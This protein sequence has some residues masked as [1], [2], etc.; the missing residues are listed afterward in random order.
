MG[1]DFEE[2]K[3]LLNN[4]AEFIK[5][6]ESLGHFNI[7]LT[8]AS[9]QTFDY[10]QLHKHVENITVNTGGNNFP[11]CSRYSGGCTAYNCETHYI[12][13]NISAYDFSTCNF[14]LDGNFQ[15]LRAFHFDVNGEHE[16]K[17]LDVDDLLRCICLFNF[18]AANYAKKTKC[19]LSLDIKLMDNKERILVTK[20][21]PH[22]SLDGNYESHSDEI[23]LKLK[24]SQDDMYDKI[25][26]NITHCLKN[27]FPLFQFMENKEGEIKKISED[28]ITDYMRAFKE[29]FQK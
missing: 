9:K 11:T 22:R 18:F 7:K 21:N 8:L 25:L 19:D 12:C 26:E 29:G 13:Q 6:I 2:R 23:Q 28:Y 15:M 16:D 27:I 24:I 4:N 3:T 10:E 17:I 14:S 5:K 20:T 1:V